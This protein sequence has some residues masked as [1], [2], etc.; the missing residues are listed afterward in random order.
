[1]RKVL[2]ALGI[3]VIWYILFKSRQRNIRDLARAEI[4]VRGVKIR[5][6]RAET[7]L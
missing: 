2:K 7:T 3:Q 6:G 5:S 1:M 4:D